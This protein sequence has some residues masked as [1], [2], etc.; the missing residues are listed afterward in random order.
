MMT[1]EGGAQAKEYLAKYAADRVRT[2]SNA[3][4]GSTFGCAECHDHKFDPISTADFYSLAAYFADVKQWGV[5]T[6][7]PYTPNPDLAGFS[8]NHPFPPEIV[9]DSPVLKRRLD[10]KRAELAKA[11]G[12]IG[13]AVRGDRHRQAMFERWKSETRSFLEANPSGWVA[14][15]PVESAL[16]KGASVDGDT[17]VL[18]GKMGEDRLEFQA[19]AAT[20]VAAFRIE[21]L[22]HAKHDGSVARVVN[23]AAR[24][25]EVLFSASLERADGGKATPVRIERADADFKDPNYENGYE[26]LGVS[27]MWTASA[28]HMKEP[29]TAVYVLQTP[30]RVTKGDRL[31]FNFKQCTIGC[32]RVSVSPI[33]SPALP[34]SKDFAK[35]LG[36]A[37]ASADKDAGSL[38]ML[39]YIGSTA[40]EREARD[41]IVALDREVALCREG[42]SPALITRAWEPRV[43]RV[44]PRGNWQDESGPVVQP[45]PPHFLPQGGKSSA[46]ST[47][48]DLAKWMV[49]AE[50]P[51]TSRT[52]VNRFWKQFFG[53]GLCATVDDLGAQGEWP[54]HPELLDWLAVEFRESRWDVKHM[55]RLMVTSSTYR[56]SSNLS[57][58][59]REIDPANRLL[60]AQSPRRLEAEFVRDNALFAAGLLGLVDV[61]GPSAKPYQPAGYYEN[62]QFPTRDYV[63]DTDERQYR[64]GVYSHWQRTFLHPMLAN[65]DAP[66]REECTAS[67]TVSNTPQQALTLLNDPSFVEAARALALRA[68]AAGR[69]DDERLNQIFSLALSR[70]LKSR[71]RES[72]ASFLSDVRARI[73]SKADDPAKMDAVGLSP[74]P[75]GVDIAELAAWT[76]VARVVLNLHES[77]TRY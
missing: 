30:V 19:P 4:L 54:S 16:P 21:L 40:S 77:I 34:P 7:Y 22:P 6:D 72:L 17:A 25:P 42:K 58:K 20:T 63:A 64:R 61:G 26:V 41:R 12:E 18:S 5:Y 45:T 32:L 14:C 37:I 38:P 43:T 51:L 44:L 47:R 35:K 57:P 53:N 70:S 31:V 3:F 29:Q 59:A 49:S 60:S 75:E 27:R 68:M 56:Q 76:N 10:R 1:R 74:V 9:V 71:E 48:L 24:T 23:R 65:F 69:T 13:Q 2:V 50:N 55:V 67:R 36:T 15:K 73:A 62:I 39:T 33:A 52:V 28:A 66:S 11:I 46:R 8:N